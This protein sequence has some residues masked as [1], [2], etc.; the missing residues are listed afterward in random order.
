MLNT[1]TQKLNN[2]IDK[3]ELVVGQHNQNIQKLQELSNLNL[4]KPNIQLT[5]H[6]SFKKKTKNLSKFKNKHSSDSPQDSSS[7]IILSIN[8]NINSNCDI[9]RYRNKIKLK[10]KPP[11][12]SPINNSKSIYKMALEETLLKMNAKLD[13]IGIDVEPLRVVIPQIQ[14][15]MQRQQQ[16]I[17]TLKQELGTQAKAIA[18]LKDMLN[19]VLSGEVKTTGPNIKGKPKN[20]NRLFLKGWRRVNGKLWMPLEVTGLVTGWNKYCQGA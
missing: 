6:E 8:S 13:K 20:W 14:E 3:F 16:Q 11:N 5:T 10:H 19:K 17:L 12:H 18:D 7:S 1:L 4:Q 15:N 9:N 2:K